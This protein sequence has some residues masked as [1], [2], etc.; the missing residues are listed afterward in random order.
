MTGNGRVEPQGAGTVS[1]S[2]PIRPELCGQLATG[3]DRHTLH[4][5]FEITGSQDRSLTIPFPRF[6]CDCASVHRCKLLRGKPRRVVAAVGGLR[7]R[8]SKRS[9]WPAQDDNAASD[10]KSVHGDTDS[11]RIARMLLSALAITICAALGSTGAAAQSWQVMS[12]DYG[13]NNNRVDVTNT[14]RRPGERVQLPGEQ[15]HHGRRSSP[16]EG[17]DPAHPCP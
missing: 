15:C 16:R 10:W 13:V 6:S 8:T 1:W 17:Q 12:A 11:M 14:V 7:L 5:T 2:A 9:S 4:L 3:P